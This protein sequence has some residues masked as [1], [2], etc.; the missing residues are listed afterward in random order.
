MA[1]RTVVTRGFGNGTFNGTIPLVVLR[2][3][4]PAVIVTIGGN[5]TL[6]DTAY[7]TAVL[8]DALLQTAAASDAAYYT[9]TLTDSAL[10]TAVA[11]D[12]ALQTATAGD[13]ST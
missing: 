10:Q 2:G 12:S 1:I 3:Y 9:A 7:Y 8:S 4:A 6:S 11:S 5:V 13:S